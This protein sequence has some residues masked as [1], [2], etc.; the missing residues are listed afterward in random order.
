MIVRFSSFASK[1]NFA[2]H[3]SEHHYFNGKYM[4]EKNILKC[5]LSF[6][7]RQGKVLSLESLL[8][9]KFLSP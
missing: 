8:I 7:L 9:P 2:F 5:L 4:H 3:W 6:W 1:A